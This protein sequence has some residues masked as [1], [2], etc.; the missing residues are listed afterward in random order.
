MSKSKKVIFFTPDFIARP[1]GAS[2]KDSLG[3]LKNFKDLGYEITLVIFAHDWVFKYVN[4]IND[5]EKKVDE[6][7]IIVFKKSK[8][9][10]RLTSI[11]RLDGYTDQYFNE[12]T[13]LELTEMYGNKYYDLVWLDFTY[14]WPLKNIFSESKI[15]IR[16]KNFEPLHFI[17]ENKK[18]IINFIKFIPK[19][20]SEIKSVRSSDV[21]LAITPKEKKL[22]S[23]FKSKVKLYPLSYLKNNRYIYENNKIKNVFFS[24]GSYNVKHNLN[25]LKYIINNILPILINNNITLNITGSK[26]PQKF[27]NLNNE[28]LIFHGFLD[29]KDFVNFYRKMDV[30]LA[31]IISGHGMQSKIFEPMSLGIPTLTFKTGL[32]GYDYVK[33][34]EYLELSENLNTIFSSENLK[35]ISKKTFEKS[36]KLFDY[37]FSELSEINSK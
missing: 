35:K 1:I 20:L 12:K 14:M 13:V 6:L 15:I 28:F 5:L 17:S 26:I 25:A 21:F 10:N 30:N 23:L 8:L 9:K 3:S 29:E 4:E 27:L 19:L 24:G 32:R 18:N 11:F 37:N 34:L 33:E 22:Y 31:P 36:Q 7:K 2:E 16:S